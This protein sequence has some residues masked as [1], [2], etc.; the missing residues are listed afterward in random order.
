[1][2]RE[3]STE[4]ESPSPG[5]SL[6]VLIVD[7]N[8]QA[9]KSLAMVVQLWNHDARMVHDGPGA[10]AEA[11]EYR[12]RVV[13]LDI[14]LPGMDGYRVASELRSL[15]ELQGLVMIAMTGYSRDED[16]RRSESVGIERHL[17]KPIDFAELQSLLEDVDART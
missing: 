11:L 8:V 4:V 14:G 17:V 7:D 12:P 10:I 16:F 6:R 9:A 1:M 13:L 3:A 5:G 15:P 2:P